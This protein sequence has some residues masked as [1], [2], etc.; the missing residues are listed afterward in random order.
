MRTILLQVTGLDLH[1]SKL[2][3]PEYPTIDQDALL[4]SLIDLL[5]YRSELSNEEVFDYLLANDLL[6]D[7]LDIGIIGSICF[8]VEPII[9]VVRE[10]V[11]SHITEND[12]L[13]YVTDYKQRRKDC[14]FLL[15]T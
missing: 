13:G 6:G 9:E 4:S 15:Q 12:N 5:S 10:M 8:S 2:Q 14:V 7:R 11:Q 1:L 3:H